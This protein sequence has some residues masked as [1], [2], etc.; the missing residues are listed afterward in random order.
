MFARMN[1]T[2]ASSRS[3]WWMKYI[4]ATADHADPHE[5]AE[6]PLLDRHVVGDR[7][8][9]RREHRDDR[10]PMVVAIA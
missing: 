1:S 6:Q 7:A 4:I 2:D 3:P 5:R 9:D 8:E 10:Q